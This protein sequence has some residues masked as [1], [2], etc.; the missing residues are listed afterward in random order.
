MAGCGRD[1]GDNYSYEDDSYEDDSYIASD[2]VY[3][4]SGYWNRFGDL[5]GDLLYVDIDGRWTYS[6]PQEDGSIPV[7]MSG[8]VL[9]DDGIVFETDDGS[10]YFAE[11]DGSCI[12]FMYEP[13]YLMDNSIYL[14]EYNGIWRLGGDEN[15][16]YFLFENGKFELHVASGGGHGYS[17][18]EGGG[19]LVYEGNEDELAAHYAQQDGVLGTMYFDYTDSF[20]LNGD[21][22]YWT[23]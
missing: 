19:Y 7:T 17:S 20:E 12:F 6:E 21:T 8:A 22:Y 16:D 10:G 9:T 3:E 4:M 11:F 2:L 14:S 13:F 1:S 5:E 18:Y 23:E 15:A